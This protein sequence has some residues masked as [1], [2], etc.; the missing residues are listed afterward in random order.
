MFQVE[1]HFLSFRLTA[2]EKVSDLL[3]VTLKSPRAFSG[4]TVL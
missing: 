2:L 3:G 1:A 4:F